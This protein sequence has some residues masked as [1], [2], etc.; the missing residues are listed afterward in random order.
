METVSKKKH[1]W[2]WHPTFSM[3]SQGQKKTKVEQNENSRTKVDSL[4]QRPGMCVHC[5]ILLQEYS[6][7]S[8]CNSS[9]LLK[10]SATHIPHP[11]QQD[12]KGIQ[13]NGVFVCCLTY[14]TV[15][16]FDQD[17]FRAKSQTK[18]ICLISFHTF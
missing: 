15:I 18:P 12:A 13:S 6:Y 14:G 17:I 2:L 1:R 3:A 5:I 4:R 16:F 11:G 7:E 9:G 8:R 10:G